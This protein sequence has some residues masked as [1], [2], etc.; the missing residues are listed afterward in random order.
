MLF[1][2][3][4]FC[5]F[6]SGKVGESSTTLRRRLGDSEAI[7]PP[8]NIIKVLIAKFENCIFKDNPTVYVCKLLYTWLFL[9]LVRG[10]YLEFYPKKLCM[11]EVKNIYKLKKFQ[12]SLQCI[13]CQVISSLLL[14]A[15]QQCLWIC[16]LRLVKSARIFS[17][18]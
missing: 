17:H 4:P 13:G 1:Q 2:G 18:M 16:S 10:T 15:R 14:Q 12:L 9:F 5:L 7:I 3:Y 11:S 8:K 6:F